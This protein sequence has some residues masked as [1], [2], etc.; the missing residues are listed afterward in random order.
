LIRQFIPKKTDFSQIADE[1]AQQVQDTLKTPEKDLT[2]KH[3]LNKSKKI[4]Q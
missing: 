1:F 3:P 2:M 4:K